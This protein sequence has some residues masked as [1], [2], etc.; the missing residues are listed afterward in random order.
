[1]HQLVV[2]HDLRAAAGIIALQIR[3]RDF[4]IG[5]TAVSQ[6]HGAGRQCLPF[7]HN[8]APSCWL[9]LSACSSTM[10]SNF[11]RSFSANVPVIYSSEQQSL[12]AE[13]QVPAGAVPGSRLRVS[14]QVG[15][16]G[17]I[18]MSATYSPG[19]NPLV[20]HAHSNV[21][22]ALPA[23]PNGLNSCGPRVVLCGSSISMLDVRPSIGIHPE[24]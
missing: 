21:A 17:W 10:L 5:K 11:P 8:S 22:C 24:Q 16:P 13:A 19:C 18:E 1:M 3:D 2:Q 14:V 7:F 9:T 12:A 15:P 6:A 20:S 4:I 23:I